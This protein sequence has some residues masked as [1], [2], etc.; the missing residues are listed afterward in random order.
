[1]A[2][3]VQNLDGTLTMTLD[4][5]EQDTYSG[6]QSGQLASYVTLWLKEQASTVF[7]TRFS[8]LSPEDQA[9]IMETIRNGQ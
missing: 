5:V 6:L 4:A 3:I 1:M 9:T 8:A 7:A 2:T